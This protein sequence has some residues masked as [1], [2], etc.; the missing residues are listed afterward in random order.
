MKNDIYLR[1]GLT[2]FFTAAYWIIGVTAG[3]PLLVAIVGATIYVTVV[4]KS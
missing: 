1:I 3:L 2:S 4:L